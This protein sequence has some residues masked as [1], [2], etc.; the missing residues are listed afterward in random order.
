VDSEHVSVPVVLDVEAAA[1]GA[2]EGGGVIPR[3]AQ[4]LLRFD[5][6]CPTMDRER[7][8]RFVPLLV[9]FGLRPIL[10]VVPD[11]RD[12]GLAV[13]KP[14][15]GFWEQMRAMEAAG[16]AIGL[17]GF[18]HVCTARGRGLV[19]LHRETEF[20]GVLEEM[21]REWIRA[22]LEIL[23]THGLDPAI[24]V[25]PRHGFDRATLRVLRGEGIGLISDGFARKPFVR[26]GVT[27]VPQQLWGPVAKWSGLWTICIHSNT[28]PDSLVEEL[29]GFLRRHSEQFTSVER[30][31][32]ELR[33]GGLGV[34]E[35]AYEMGSVLRIQVR[36]R[37][38]RP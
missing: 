13:A 15:P 8:E 5:D 19:P 36:R 27:W 28:A 22:G 35:R 2:I 29:R 3:P 10:A 9:E 37:M 25:A 33:P 14:D 20:A 6:L 17:H 30:A 7:W 18:R 34:L 16:A 4:Y 11:N 12:P 38:R 24:W 23:R 21:Q 26:G 1:Q 32:R 31:V